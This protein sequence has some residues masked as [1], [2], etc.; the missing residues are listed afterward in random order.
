M[1][2]M[3]GLYTYETTMTEKVEEDGRYRDHQVERS[4]QEFRSE[5][6]SRA[7]T[8]T[9][10]PVE[11]GQDLTLSSNTNFTYRQEGRTFTTT[12]ALSPTMHTRRRPRTRIGLIVQYLYKSPVQTYESDSQRHTPE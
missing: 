8:S 2:M 10:Q 6:Q 7:G 5:A 9:K 1:F 4:I 12:I 11:K 3:N